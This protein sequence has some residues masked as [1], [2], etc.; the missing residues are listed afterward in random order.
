VSPSVGRRLPRVEDDRLVRGEGRY[1]ADIVLP[2]M[3]DAVVVRSRDAHGAIVGVHTEG[4]TALEGVVAVFTAADL[5]PEAM[6]IERPFYRLT[7]DFLRQNQVVLRP[8]REPVLASDRVRRAGEPVALVVAVD[9]FVAEDAREQ[10]FVEVDPLPVVTDPE[11]ALRPDAPE[12]DPEVPGNLQGSFRVVVGEPDGAAAA[13]DHRVSARF[14][15][16][17]AVGSPLENRG[18]L[19]EYDETTGMLTVWSTTQIPHLLRSYLAPMLSL[20]EAGIRVVAPDMGGSFGGGVYPEEVLVAWAAMRLGRPIRWLEE[21]AE[22]LVN[23]RQSRDQIID[24]ELAYGAD[25][26]FVSLRMKIVQDCGAVNPFGI[27]LPHNIASHARGVYAIRHFLAEGLAVITNKTRNTP[28]RGAGRPEATFVLDRLIDMAAHHLDLDPVE[29]RRRNLIAAAEMPYDMGMLYRDGNPLIYDSGDFPD[30]MDVALETADY[31]ALRRFQMEA[32]AEGR[33]IGI[34]ISCHVEATGLGPHEGADVRVDPTGRIVVKCGSQPHG[35]SH[36]TVLAQVCADVFDVDVATVVVQTGDTA[37][38]PKGGGTFGSRSAVTA[39]SAVRMAAESARDKAIEL[40]SS[41][42]E[43]AA[44]DLVVAGGTIAP[45]GVPDAGLTLAQLA[46]AA[47]PEPGSEAAGEPGIAA[48]EYFV[49]ASVTFG[50]GTHVAVVEVDI[51]TGAVAVIDYTI[52]DDCGT[53]LNPMVVDGQQHGGAAHGIG[54]MLLEDAGYNEDGQPTN[55]T[56][57]DYLL[58]TAA[59][60]PSF[61]VVHRPHPTPLNA[62]GV[63]GAGEGATASAPAAVANAIVDA[64]RPLAVEINEMPMTPSRI[65]ALIGAARAASETGTAATESSKF[66]D[67]RS[68]R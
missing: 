38:I 13:A 63:K 3:L 36:A 39:G 12:I 60:V 40:A 52:V 42:L 45:R 23:S 49:P 6:A 22:D 37:L 18:V 7:E 16:G 35:Q 30:Q 53:M 47:R 57:M 27:T 66:D 20:P 9:R 11:A 44:D 64:L 15:I 67:W 10:V 46:G 4:A 56:F 17:R 28:V 43:I 59:D 58:P 34:G 32:S 14:R 48:T 2:G 65:V 25:G 24:G 50:S 62:L 41:L 31:D 51:E 19:A 33:A 1:L 54:N 8:V 55:V 61:K 21:R 5:P 68:D 26:A 29:I